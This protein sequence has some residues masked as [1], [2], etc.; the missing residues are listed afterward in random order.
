M[1][2]KYERPKTEVI[3]LLN[4]DIITDS[5]VEPGEVGPGGF[6]SAP[7]GAKSLLTTLSALSPW[8]EDEEGNQIVDKDGNPISKYLLDEEGNQILDE[9][10]N[11]ILNEEYVE[12]VNAS[13]N[14]NQETEQSIETESSVENENSS[15]LEAIEEIINSPSQEGSNDYSGNSDGFVEPDI[16]ETPNSGESDAGDAGW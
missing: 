16:E 1:K 2:Q 9:D 6:K 15:L 14:E 10:G 13:K 12:L 7:K 11:P 3:S 8:L 4:V 5:P